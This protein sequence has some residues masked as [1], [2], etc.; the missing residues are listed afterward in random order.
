MNLART[1]LLALMTACTLLTFRHAVDRLDGGERSLLSG[2]LGWLGLLTIYYLVTTLFD[3][4]ISQRRK[5]P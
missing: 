2:V 3:D 1:L 5:D 4:V